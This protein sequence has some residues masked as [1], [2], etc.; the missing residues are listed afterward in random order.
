VD[1][2]E[3]IEAAL[4]QARPAIAGHHVDIDTATERT[5]VHLDPRLTSAAR[6][7]LLE[8]AGQYSPAGSAI[9]VA[10]R[11]AENSVRL[12]VRDRGRG[13]GREEIAQVF[14]PFYRGAHARARR[15][16]TGMGLAIAKGLIAAQGGKVLAGNRPEGGAVFTIEIAAE[17]KP[18]RSV[19]SEVV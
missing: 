16:G 8:N 2:A 6:A 13:I 18:I 15:S 5:L 4:R 11:A 12:V 3:I 1:P 19:E 14:E 9:D 7:H 10:V 17:L